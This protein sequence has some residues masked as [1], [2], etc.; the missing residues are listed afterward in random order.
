M[1]K[2][3]REYIRNAK[4]Q[5]VMRKGMTLIEI[6]IVLV[7]MASVMTLVGVNVFGALDTGNEKTTT[8]QLQQ[9]KS[10]I[11][12][13][14]LNYRKMPNSLDDLINTPDR[15]SLID[16]DTVPKDGWDNDFSFE[17]NGNRIK[18]YSNGADGLPN[19]EDDIVVNVG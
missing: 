15:R 10:A 3:Y 8:I 7:I 16:S 13:Y 12:S 17:K 2:I 9:F 1:I 14:K 5:T 6:M 4:K 19:T 18:I 11:E